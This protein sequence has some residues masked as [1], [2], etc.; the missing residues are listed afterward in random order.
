[1][2]NFKFKFNFLFNLFKKNKILK[3]TNN[4]LENIRK[5]IKLENFKK[6][7][8]EKYYKVYTKN[9]KINYSLNLM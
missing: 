2:K 1:M 5:F 7:I 3:K 8:V 9:F 4:F 6:K